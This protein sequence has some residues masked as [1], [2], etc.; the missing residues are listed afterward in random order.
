MRSGGAS[1]VCA[2]RDAPPNMP[3]GSEPPVMSQQPGLLSSTCPS[4]TGAAC[5]TGPGMP[6]A[7]DGETIPN[8][9]PPGAKAGGSAEA[10][11]ELTLEPALA[12]GVAPAIHA[13]LPAAT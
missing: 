7:A 6:E 3:P 13:M 9:S 10:E 11:P 4:D 1:V 5:S 2:G 12:T 8:S